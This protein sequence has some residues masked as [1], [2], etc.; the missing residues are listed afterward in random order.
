[1]QRLDQHMTARAHSEHR[2]QT[3]G[4]AIRSSRSSLSSHS[5][6]PDRF[7]CEVTCMSHASSS[8]VLTPGVA[9]RA[10]HGRSV[11]R[12]GDVGDEVARVDP[13][14]ASILA[15]GRAKRDVAL[16]DD[17]GGPSKPMVTNWL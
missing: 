15:L 3:L 13:N 7:M 4:S 1:M 14:V 10:G 17:D 16:L 11:A 9:E 5:K 8:G 2:Q 12:S 6:S